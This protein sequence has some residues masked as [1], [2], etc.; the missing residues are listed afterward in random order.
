[1]GSPLSPIV[2]N[3]YMEHFE[4][5]AIDTS[6]LKPKSWKIYGDDANAICQHGR[7]KLEDFLKQLNIQLEH[8]KFTMEI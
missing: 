5:I 4:K 3:L 2:S 7:D 1:M 6:P 8:I